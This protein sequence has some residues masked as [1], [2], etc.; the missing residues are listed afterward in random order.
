MSSVDAVHTDGTAVL[1]LKVEVETADLHTR[2]DWC[3]RAGW[4]T[5]VDQDM[6]VLMNELVLV[7]LGAC[8]LVEQE[9]CSLVVLDACSLVAPD[10]CSLVALNARSLVALETRGLVD[11]LVSCSTWGGLGTRAD[12]CS[13]ADP[14]IRAVLGGNSAQ[15]SRVIPQVGVEADS[16]LDLF[17]FLK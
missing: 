7:A 1:L 8:S 5:R 12:R 4:D 14:N 13:R 10:I 16:G 6:L 3:T 15:G 2:F 17:D 9:A 11:K